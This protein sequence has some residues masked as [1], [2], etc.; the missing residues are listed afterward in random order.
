MNSDIRIVEAQPFFPQIRC[1]TPLKFGAV[2]VEELP[3]CHVRVLAENRQGRRAEGWGAILLMDLWGWPSP[4]VPH[5]TRQEVM[6]ETVEAICR[7]AA[8]HGQYG[9]P[10][11]LFFDLLDEFERLGE[12]ACR[13]RNLPEMMPHLNLLICASPLDAAVHDAFGNVNA[14]D[15][16]AGYG[17]EHCRH[18]L[19]RYLGPQFKGRYLADFLQPMAPSLPA[20]HL[21][22]GLDKLTESQIDE[23][24][25]KDDLPV[26][27]D[28]W[29]RFE[30]L[31]FLKVKLTGKDLAWDLDRFGAVA[32]IAYSEGRRLGIEDF[33][34][35]ADTNEQCESPEYMIE[36][37][38]KLKEKDPRAYDDLIYI[39]QPTERDLEAHAWEMSRLAALKPV[40][41][42][43][44]LT[45][46]ETVDRAVE[47]G[48]SGI[49]L[50]ACKCQ[51]NALVLAAK[52]EAL[53]I[54][55]TV[56]DLT[57]PGISLIQSVGIAAHLRTLNGVEANSRQF[58]PA[59][60]EP[61]MPVHP[62]VFRF[63]QGRIHTASIRGAG[64]G[65]RW[66]QIGRRF[67]PAG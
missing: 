20:Y 44:S 66:D 5:E 11:D 24:D 51:S 50:K 27:L 49:G 40:I 55:Y 16:Y 65:Y 17:R 39:E 12:E 57:N 9:H 56:Q 62:D 59:A 35:T 1:R 29:I 46:P 48:W 41:I 37:L 7:V 2:V 45:G 36:F 42:D 52:A 53:G 15:T 13:R 21:V 33:R 25:P 60:N 31:R 28:Q 23:T 26:S 22:G 38:Q 34:F 18:D 54:P 64:L 10:L 58:F 19:S 67:E 6:I 61:E 47:L 32:N 63:R 4:N 30:H 3:F 43:E 8:G 14:I